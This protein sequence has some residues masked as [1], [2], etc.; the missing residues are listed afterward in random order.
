SSIEPELAVSPDRLGLRRRRLPK[1]PAA[2]QRRN[3]F[4]DF[5]ESWIDERL[6]LSIPIA[7]SRLY[8]TLA[9][10]HYRE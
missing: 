5:G 8:F 1:D 2:S 6:V 7:N 9:I 4:E 3:A 10:K